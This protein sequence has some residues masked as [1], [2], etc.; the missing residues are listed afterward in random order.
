MNGK[1]FRM[2]DFFLREKDPETKYE[3]CTKRETVHFGQ[4]KLL[5]ADIFFILH[6]VD[7]RKHPNP[8]L[9]AIGAAPGHHYPILHQLFPMIEFHLFDPRPIHFA[10]SS[11]SGGPILHQQSFTSEDALYWKGTSYV[12]TR[13]LYLTSDIR[14][15]DHTTTRNK[16]RTDASHSRRYG[17]A[18]GMDR[19]DSTEQ[20]GNQNEISVR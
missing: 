14:S 10:T 20:R 18:E 19:N 7:L 4:V 15:V 6:F 12:T 2:T 3:K 11:S 16:R 13:G 1:P 8:I 17:H 9:L 5:M